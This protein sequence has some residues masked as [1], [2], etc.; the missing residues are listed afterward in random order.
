MFFWLM[1]C[2]L[3]F[4]V[5]DI[6]SVVT[7]ARLSSVFIALMLFLLGFLLK[8]FPPDIISQAGL[9]QIGSFSAAYIVFHMGTMIEIEQ[10]K[11]EWRTVLMA[12]ISMMVAVGMVLAVSFFI[13]RE[14]SIVSAPIINGGIVATQIMTKAALEKGFTMAASLGTIVFAVQKFVGTPFA[15]AFGLREAKEVLK[16]Y[17]ADLAKGEL[18]P[19]FLKATQSEAE[20]SS[21]KFWHK[22]QKFYT[23][24]VCISITAIGAWLATELGTLVPSI[25]Y[26]IW[27]LVLG[28]LAAHTGLVPNN[29][30]DRGI[31]SGFINAVV[32]SSLIPALAN[33]QI[34]DLLT[35]AVQT[36]VLFAAVMIGLFVF[37]YILPTWKIV[38]HR[39]L[40]FGI[41][42]IQLLGFP[43]NYLV[44]NE[45]ANASTETP[46]EKQVVL[47]RLMPAYIISNFV[48]VTSLSIVV[49][50]IAA[51]L[52]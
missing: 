27:A 52:L 13:G 32:F 45:V 18:R 31:S 39:N 30:L 9:T 16:E 5:G 24:F 7:K 49:A 29:I 26:S 14:N 12:L 43:A 38:G 36:I 19:E 48:S 33:I 1:V 50:G 34:G 25:N 44:V 35:L 15:S 37:T 3:L 11:K 41:S 40:A 46:E 2:F 28:I 6:L 20:V 42:V 51:T 4:A 17:R 21:H 10:L 47:S 8:I 23:P 22:H